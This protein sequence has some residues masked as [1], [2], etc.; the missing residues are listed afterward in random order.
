MKLPKINSKAEAMAYAVEKADGD[1]EK[2][3]KIYKLF[4][5][6]IQLPDIDPISC[7]RNGYSIWESKD[8]G[9]IEITTEQDKPEQEI[10]V[11]GI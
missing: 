3:E 2:A 10:L 9:T 1:L 11:S 7:V 5:D 6:N 8:C 4:A